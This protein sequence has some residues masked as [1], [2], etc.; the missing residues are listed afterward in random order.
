MLFTIQ[1]PSVTGLTSA[2]VNLGKVENKGFELSLSSRNLVGS[3]KWSTNFNITFNRNKVLEMSSDAERIFS[4]S[5]GRP[6]YAVTQ[7]GYPIGSFYGRRFLGI[8]RTEQEANEY[9][10]QPNAH[11]G[12][13]KWKDIDGNG[14][15]NDN[16]KEI[17][18]S[19]FPKYYFGFNNTFTYKNFSLDIMTS[20]NVGQQVY[21]NSFYLNNSGVQNNAQYVYDNRWIS[22]DQPGNGLFGRAIRGGKNDNTQ[23]S[24]VYLFDASFWRIRNVTFA[25]SLPNALVN[26]LGIGSARVYAT[27]TNLYTITSYPGYDPETNISGD[28]VTSFGLDFGAYPQARTITFGVNLSF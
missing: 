5:G 12:D 14:V 26:R 4:A 16:D 27:A 6:A 8:F 24:S 13:V 3:L 28:S 25:Y 10:A 11:A 20:G 18:G 22:P 2:V 9:K 7:A 23:F 1:T 19:P 21:N 15:I 17:I